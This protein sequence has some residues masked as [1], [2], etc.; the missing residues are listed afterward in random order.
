MT[1]TPSGSSELSIC[2]IFNKGY[3]PDPHQKGWKAGLCR[4]L[5]WNGDFTDWG[6]AAAVVGLLILYL[7]TGW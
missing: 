6:L 3:A 4:F 1:A 5:T 7:L 2:R